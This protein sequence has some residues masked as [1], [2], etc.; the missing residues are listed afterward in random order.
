MNVTYRCPQCSHTVR[1]EITR[2]SLCC[3]DC[4]ASTA[5]PAEAWD[6]QGRLTRCLVCPSVD[7]FIRKDFPQRLGLTIVVAG[8]ALSFVTWYFYWVYLTFAV[9]FAT[10][11]VD[12]V[13]YAVMGESLVCYRC[14]A[15]YRNAPGQEMHGGFELATHERYRQLAARLEPSTVRSEA[16]SRS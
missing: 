3:P 4:A 7:L 15:Q 6:D 2:D 5:V 13:L 1:A 9:L 12:M 14:G 10:A 11:A 16:S 8:F